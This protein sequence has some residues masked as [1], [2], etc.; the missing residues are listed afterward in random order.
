L[1]SPRSPVRCARRVER[2]TSRRPCRFPFICLA[3]VLV[4]KGEVQAG[5][6]QEIR[7]QA[8]CFCTCVCVRV[9]VCM[10][11]CVCVGTLRDITKALV[12]I[13]ATATRLRLFFYWLRERKEMGERSGE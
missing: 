4:L 10:C 9:C 12:C 8:I 1:A 2:H 6:R 7:R 11:V 13:N 5:P 3:G